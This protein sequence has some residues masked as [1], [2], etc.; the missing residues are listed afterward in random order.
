MGQSQDISSSYAAMAANPKYRALVS[1]R[2]RFSLLLTAI[3]LATYYG[4]MLVVA[5]APARLGVPILEGGSV[6]VGWPIGAC[7]VIGYWLL[8]GIYIHRANGEF[9]ALSQDLIKEVG[10]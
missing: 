7:L 4:Y 6:S 5:F 1:K 9:E 2:A 10:R 8:T 3:V